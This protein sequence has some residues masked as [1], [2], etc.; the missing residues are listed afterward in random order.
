MKAKV[1][2]RHSNNQIE[3]HPIEGVNIDALKISATSKARKI[4]GSKPTGGW[5]LDTNRRAFVKG[6]K[7][8]K[9]FCAIYIDSIKR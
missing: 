2:V 8:S 7:R 3:S 6:G 5:K 4:G 9:V 1:E